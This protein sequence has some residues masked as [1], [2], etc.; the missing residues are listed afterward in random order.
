MVTTPDQNNLSRRYSHVATAPYCSLDPSETPTTNSEDWGGHEAT[1]PAGLGA[2]RK[3]L[4]E[5]MASST[6]RNST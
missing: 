6:R 4:T 2:R 1:E 5:V 3:L